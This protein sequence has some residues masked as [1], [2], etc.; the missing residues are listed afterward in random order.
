M[1]GMFPIDGIANLHLG[2]FFNILFIKRFIR[3]SKLIFT[4]ER[5]L[6]LKSLNNG[7]LDGSGFPDYSFGR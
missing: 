3:Q 4:G 1:E 7:G 5:F 6:I 2:Y